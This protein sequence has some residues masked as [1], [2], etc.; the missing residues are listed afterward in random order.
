MHGRQYVTSPWAGADGSMTTHPRGIEPQRVRHS[1]FSASLTWS[2][3]TEVRHGK[4]R[5]RTADL[6]A[7][8]RT[9]FSTT[10]HSAL[11][12]QHELFPAEFAPDARIERHPGARRLP[13]VP[14]AQ[15]D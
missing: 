9:Q 7:C 14:V 8:A 13:P 1:L 6:G 10:R 11:R 3:Q 15:T 5:L 12:G 2:R 4:V